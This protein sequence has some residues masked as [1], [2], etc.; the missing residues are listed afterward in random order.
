MCSRTQRGQAT[1]MLLGFDFGGGCA[2]AKIKT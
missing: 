2:A 1:H